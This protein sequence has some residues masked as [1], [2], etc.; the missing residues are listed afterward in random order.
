[1]ERNYQKV[2]G[3]R[4]GS[5][6]YFDSGGFAYL[7]EK[8]VEDH[9]YLRC[10]Y[11]KRADLELACEGRAIINLVSDV[12]SVTKRHSCTPDPADLEVLKVKSEMKK[13]AASSQT[14]FS[15]LHRE[16]LEN[17]PPAVREKVPMTKVLSSMRA[18][19]RRT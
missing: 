19:R 2:E 8:Q 10:K 15:L 9:L 7:K 13:A 5:F 16:A 18:A 12:L 3:Q 6:N 17:A 4:V 14:G 11:S 1:M